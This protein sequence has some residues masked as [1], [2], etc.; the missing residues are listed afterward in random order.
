MYAGTVPQHH[1]NW[2]KGQFS[3]LPHSPI[4]HPEAAA[5]AQPEDVRRVQE[6]MQ[7]GPEDEGGDPRTPRSRH[8]IP[9]TRCSEYKELTR[10]LD[11]LYVKF[12]SSRQ[13]WQLQNEVKKEINLTISLIRALF[14]PTINPP[15]AK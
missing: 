9:E 10:R 8:P 11:E 5:A 14:E 13:D 12:E 1:K 15:A 3:R 6:E 2:H 7:A 4:K